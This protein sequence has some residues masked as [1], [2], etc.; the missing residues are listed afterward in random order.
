MPQA[1]VIEE[2]KERRPARTVPLGQVG[3][4]RVLIPPD[5]SS[6]TLRPDI[7]KTTCSLLL[8][9]CPTIG[10]SAQQHES[11]AHAQIVAVQILI[12]IIRVG[13]RPNLPLDPLRLQSRPG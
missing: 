7:D 6:L 1:R 8:H 11:G 2:R 5:S 3:N 13:G 12:L 10:A 9:I 4:P